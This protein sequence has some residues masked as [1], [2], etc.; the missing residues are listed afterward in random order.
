MLFIGFCLFKQ[1]L[2][3]PAHKDDPAFSPENLF[4]YLPIYVF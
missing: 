2:L 4:I 3:T 1:S